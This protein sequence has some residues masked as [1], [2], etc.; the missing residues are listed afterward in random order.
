MLIYPDDD[1]FYCIR[2]SVSALIAHLSELLIYPDAHLSEFDCTTL[3]IALISIRARPRP[4]ESWSM[5]VV[6]SQS[7]PLLSS[8]HSDLWARVRLYT[9]K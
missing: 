8:A 4:T 3:A 2:N 7:L 6:S 5:L 1:Q 9:M